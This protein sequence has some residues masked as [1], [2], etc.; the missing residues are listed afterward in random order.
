M[1]AHYNGNR[2]INASFVSMSFQMDLYLMYGG[3]YYHT[4]LTTEGQIAFPE[5]VINK[6]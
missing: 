1:R 4:N 6:Q 2:S 3:A 5:Y